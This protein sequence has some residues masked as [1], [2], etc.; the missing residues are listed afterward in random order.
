MT[1]SAA[2]WRDSLHVLKAR[3]Y[4]ALALLWPLLGLIVSGAIV[5]AVRIAG[6]FELF[7]IPPVDTR[8]VLIDFASWA[9]LSPGIAILAIAL[10]PGRRSWSRL[11]TVHVSAA[12]SLSIAYTAIRPEYAAV[13]PAS[14]AGIVAEIS[15]RVLAFGGIVLTTWS[16][17]L[18]RAMLQNVREERRIAAAAA[19]AD[20]WLL[21]ST[22]SYLPSVLHDVK[23]SLPDAKH[24]ERLTVAV[25]DLL[26]EQLNGI[27][28][29]KWTVSDEVRLLDRIAD[30]ESLRGH[31]VRI[32]VDMSRDLAGESV[33]RGWIAAVVPPMFV[34][35]G[36]LELSIIIDDN[37]DALRGTIT[38]AD[39]PL[40]LR[41]LPKPVKGIASVYAGDASSFAR[42][43][44]IH[45][46]PLLVTAWFVTSA[47]LF[48]RA[49]EH[50]YPVTGWSFLISPVRALMMTASVAA[51]VWFAPI[52]IVGRWRWM[53]AVSLVSAWF[54]EWIFMD[55]VIAI[56]TKELVPQTILVATLFALMGLAPSTYASLPIGAS[57]AVVRMARES[58]AILAREAASRS[59]LAELEAN[60][61]HQQMNPHF[62]FNALNSLA[63]LIRNSS[64]AAYGFVE[65]LL[66]F[67]S[68][69]AGC[70]A[71]LIDLQTEIGLTF[72]YLDIERTR[73]SRAIPVVVNYGD[74]SA[75]ARVPP[76]CIQSLVENAVKHGKCAEE[77][78]PIRVTIEIVAGSLFVR[79]ENIVRPV[80]VRP[81]QGV[82]LILLS[83]RLRALFGAA[84]GLQVSHIDDLYRSELFMPVV[85]ATRPL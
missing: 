72:E 34:E 10:R 31:R 6:G 56:I 80:S 21:A 29:A 70:D 79:V 5:A 62:L 60:L 51:A 11:I 25:A 66:N 67:Y 85:M 83:Q 44:S 8:K 37:D 59:R 64:D 32:T 61:L 1:D 75:G 48:F 52:R 15:L 63:A 14:A 47:A 42:A 82:G 36:D 68:A 3:E 71:Q 76:L 35:A 30:V 58:A 53:V 13:R 17:L 20:Q 49:I 73:F 22:S 2:T 84:A 26:R 54:A 4:A 50:H 39:R 77:G 40:A 65:K 16:V 12:L 19:A 46:T 45:L 7:G 38:T 69:I 57:L 43:A 74:G 27:S 78:E 18:F 28:A 41:D 81:K 9:I 55:A 23:A 33:P 24:A